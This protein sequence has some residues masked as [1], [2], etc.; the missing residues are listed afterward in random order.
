MEEDEHSANRDYDRDSSP[1]LPPPSL[2]VN[3][4]TGDV[5]L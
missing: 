3:E 5:S 1:H 2:P 4:D